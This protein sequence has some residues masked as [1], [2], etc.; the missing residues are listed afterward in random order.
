MEFGG[1]DGVALW[2][3]FLRLKLRL[4][5]WAAR[6]NFLGFGSGKPGEEGDY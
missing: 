1:G 2:S 5:K 6:Q 3:L 4:V